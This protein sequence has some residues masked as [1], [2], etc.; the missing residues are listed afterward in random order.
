MITDT[1]LNELAK[2]ANQE[3]AIFPNYLARGTTDITAV[4]TDDTTID[5]EIGTREDLTGVRTANVVEWSGI[6]SGA[7]VQDTSN[8]DDIGSVGVF[9]TITSATTDPLQIGVA[10]NGVLQTTNFDVE[11]ITNITYNRV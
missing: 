4:N 7:D 2:A 8:G 3:S 11:V 9:N 6:F 10:V 1:H 5:G